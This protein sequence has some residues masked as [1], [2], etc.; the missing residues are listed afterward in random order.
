M[1]DARSQLHV[2]ARTSL[3]TL[4]AVGKVMSDARVRLAAA[5][6][7]HGVLLRLVRDTI[8]QWRLR[9]AADGN[10][11]VDVE[12]LGAS[13]ARS[14]ARLRLPS[15]CRVVNAT[16]IVVHT[17][18]GR[19]P[20]SKMAADH[21]AQMAQGY[22][23]LELDLETGRRKS[24][25][26]HLGKLLCAITDAE[27]VLV[28]NNNAAA[29]LLIMRA[30]AFRSEVVV[31]RGELVEIGDSFRLPDIMKAGG[32]RLVEVGAT[33]RT[34][35]ADYQTAIGSKTAM[36][37]KAHTS[38][39]KTIGFTEQVPV[40]ALAACAHEHGL[41]C[42]YDLGSGMLCR[43]QGVAMVD[44]P[45]VQEAL[46]AGADLVSFSGDKLLGGGQ[47]GVIAGRRD[48]ITK[49]AKSPIMRALRPGRLALAALEAVALAYLDEKRLLS[50]NPVFRMLGRNEGELRA[51]AERLAQQLRQ[52]GISVE[53]VRSDGQVG[54]G[55]LPGLSLPGWAVRIESAKSSG[56]SAGISQKASSKLFLALLHGKPPVL[57]VLREGRVVLDVRAM[58]AGEIDRVA[59]AVGTAVKHALVR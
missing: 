40:A 34:R 39:F 25:Q 59:D 57:A 29:I 5:G 48:L 1:T 45:A 26:S 47:S 17:N 9:L 14:A 12:A 15:L 32:A 38:N 3:R 35:I 53:V 19:A 20:L 11:A 43:P 55:A 24:R 18:L 6:L 52:R 46:R 51:E 30:L 16:G 23:N 58:E 13:V 7:D 44:E 10:A 49:L 50:E 27:D 54:G 21:V 31:S 4:P 56:D 8:A 37:F 28:V 36:L 33:N 2:Q 42:V 41:P 22:T